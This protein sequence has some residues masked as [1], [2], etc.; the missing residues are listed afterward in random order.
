MRFAFDIGGLISKYPDQFRVLIRTLHD[1]GHECFI[2]TDMHGREEVLEQLAM[3]GFGF[4]PHDRIK[5]ADYQGCGEFCK[6]LLLKHLRIDIFFDDFPGYVQ[7]DSTLGAAPIRLLAMPDGFRPY[8]HESWKVMDNHDFGR[9][10][11][12]LEVLKQRAEEQK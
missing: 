9:R 1:A 12:S 11:I 2:I 3:N 4:I 7:W 10:V 5:T 8:W 6:A